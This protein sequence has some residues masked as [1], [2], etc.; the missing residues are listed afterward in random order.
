MLKQIIQ[1]P[2]FDLSYSSALLAIRAPRTFVGCR[3]GERYAG[4]SKMHTFA[5]MIHGFRMLMPFIDVITMRLLTASALLGAFVIVLW[6]FAVYQV[7]A[8]QP[9]TD[10]FL[11]TLG[12]LSFITVSLF[13]NFLT[14]FTVL[15]RSDAITLKG[16]ERRAA[17]STP[18]DR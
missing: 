16:I 17:I 10:A 5:L 3:R 4:K 12:V 15:S 7:L 13:G 8:G 11:V 14:L 9:L 1:H 6:A 18:D 2:Y